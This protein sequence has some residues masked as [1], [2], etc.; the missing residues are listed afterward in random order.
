M[1][2]RKTYLLAFSETMASSSN[3]VKALNAID[4]VK[5]W[6]T[7]M[8]HAFF[9]VSD[10]SARHLANKIRELCPRGRFLICEIGE[11]RQGWLTK[12]GWHIINNQRLRPRET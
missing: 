1:S 4:E 9:V 10:K 5:T 7:E 11:N 2:D 12:D 6:R 3:V 8:P